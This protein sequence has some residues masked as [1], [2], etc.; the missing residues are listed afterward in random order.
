MQGNMHLSMG[1]DRYL[2]KSFIVSIFFSQVSQF[3][4]ESLFCASTGEKVDM[5]SQ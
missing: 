2:A 3:I 5:P 1:G 4:K